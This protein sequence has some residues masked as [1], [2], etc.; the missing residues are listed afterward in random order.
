M[1][2]TVKELARYKFNT[3]SD[4]LS[5]YI[6]FLAMFVGI[7]VFGQSMKVSSL[8]F[9][10]TIE[11]FIV[12][13]FIWNIMMLAYSDTAN[14]IVGDANRGTLEQLNMSS[15]G[16]SSILVVRS[17]CNIVISVLISFILLF[18][19]M[20][21]TK[22]WLN[23][24]FCSIFIPIFI[25]VFSILGISLIFGGLALIFKS[26]KSLLNIIQYFLIGLVLPLPENINGILSILLPFRPSIEAVYR[27]MLYGDSIMNFSPTEFGIMVINAAIYF[28]I[29]FL[30]FEQ[31]CKVAKK[32]ALLGQY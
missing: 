29:G 17:L 5:S 4:I 19:I 20:F 3:F 28:L 6:L 23:I 31:C 18:L 10:N 11:G 12:G 1:E 15:I 2:K 16:L 13:Y 14:N 32:R 30:I 25:G 21:T 8:D 22:Y 27:I 26:I 9:G 7:K 24:S